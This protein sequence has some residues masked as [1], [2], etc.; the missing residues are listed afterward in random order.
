MMRKIFGGAMAFSVVGAVLL[1]GVLAWQA[2]DSVS[3][4]NAV[5]IGG[6]DATISM[7]PGAPNGVLLGPNGHTT[8]V[9][10]LD[11]TNTGT[12]RLGFAQDG[13]GNSISGRVLIDS[14]QPVGL[15]DETTCGSQNFSGVTVFHA[16]DANTVLARF[17]DNGAS[18]PGA[19]AVNMSVAPG[20]PDS[21]QSDVVS[22]TAIVQMVT[23]GN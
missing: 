10:L 21:C 1:G 14:V 18:M 17:G 22:W 19:L 2:S 12:F 5:G 13:Q 3:S 11:L 15:P 23:L 7:A 8:K 6:L 9:A 4:S 20:A 16:A